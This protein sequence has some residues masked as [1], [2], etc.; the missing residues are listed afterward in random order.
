MAIRYKKY[1]D[2]PDL[3]STNTIQ[4]ITEDGVKTCIPMVKANRDY[5]E[6]LEWVANGGVTEDAD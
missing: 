4:R 1:A 5:K 2:D 3:G 6:Y